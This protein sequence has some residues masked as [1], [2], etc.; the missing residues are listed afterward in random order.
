M[1]LRTL[2]PAERRTAAL[3]VAALAVLLALALAWSLREELKPAPRTQ[4]KPIRSRLVAVLEG[5]MA[6]NT[7]PAERDRFKAWVA[8]GATPE[9][10]A[11]VAPIVSNN[12]AS[13]HDRGG[14]YPR[15]ASFE[16]L[17]PLALEAAPEGLAGFIS[18]RGLHLFGIPLLFL[19][20]LAGYLRRS[21][22]SHRKPLALAST[23]TVAVDAAQWWL[24]QGR[25]VP[26]WVPWA[27]AAALALAMAVLAGVVLRELQGT[28]RPA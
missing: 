4:A 17:R 9:G 8:D 11:L 12:C 26:L 10:Y 20:A 23:L 1:T 25:P 6:V 14:Q 2:P 15:L 13:C 24:R 16:D 22:W 18:P 3:A 28:G 7:T 19:V 5:A 21:A 27:A